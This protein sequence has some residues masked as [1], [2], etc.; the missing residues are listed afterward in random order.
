MAADVGWLTF[1]IQAVVGGL[2][3][4]MTIACYEGALDTPTPARFYEICERHRVT[5]V[6]ARADAARMLR[7]FGDELA[8]EHPLRASS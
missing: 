4:G 6:L 7:K 5:K 1:P 2:A 3:C 8:A